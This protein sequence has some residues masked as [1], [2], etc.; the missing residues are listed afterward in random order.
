[1]SLQVT[2]S[3][4]GIA[5]RITAIDETEG[6]EEEKAGGVGEKKRIKK[7]LVPKYRLDKVSDIG[8]GWS[9]PPPLRILPRLSIRV[10]SS[11]QPTKSDSHAAK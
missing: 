3:L 6:G 4:V 9:S 5:G 2:L 1:M 10:T 11:S 8:L 7:C